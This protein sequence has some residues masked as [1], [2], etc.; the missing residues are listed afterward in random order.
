MFNDKSCKKRIIIE[1]KAINVMQVRRRAGNEKYLK[2]INLTKGSIKSIF[3]WLLTNVFMM[4]VFLMRI[5]SMV[6]GFV[7]T[8]QPSRFYMHDD[9]IKNI[10]RFSTTKGH[11]HL[12]KKRKRKK[13]SLGSIC[14]MHHLEFHLLR[15][16]YYIIIM[17]NMD[18]NIDL[19]NICLFHPIEI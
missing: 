5:F 6:R 16:A 10:L 2:A 12:K 13:T 4:D 3:T 1:M 9:I 17:V 19:S 7:R 14:V 8:Q 11:A 18:E 15:K